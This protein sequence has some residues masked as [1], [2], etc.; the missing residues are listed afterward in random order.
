MK[1]KYGIYFIQEL[2]RDAKYPQI[3]LI[4]E[5]ISHNFVEI[6]ESNLGT[7]TFQTLLDK[8]NAF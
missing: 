2:I 8:I 1:H 6:S 3:K 5:L 4:L 7:H